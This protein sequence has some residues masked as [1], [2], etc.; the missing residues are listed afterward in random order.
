MNSE[1]K[2]SVSR[3]LRCG[4]TC[5]SWLPF[6]IDVIQAQKWGLPADCYA[7]G[8]PGFWVYRF[9]SVLGANVGNGGLSDRKQALMQHD[10][11]AQAWAGRC[12][13]P[14]FEEGNAAL[15]THSSGF[16]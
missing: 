10:Q 16:D 7:T 3:A 9:Q 8:G 5:Q 14:G 4:D 13:D 12:L 1:W 6:V 15:K 11:Q 2:R